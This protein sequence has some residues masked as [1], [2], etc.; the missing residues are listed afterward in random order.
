MQATPDK[1][2]HL[3]TNHVTTEK[4][5]DTSNDLG[6]SPRR[7]Q[8][9]PPIFTKHASAGV[10]LVVSAFTV[11]LAAGSVSHWDN[12]FPPRMRFGISSVILRYSA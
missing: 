12:G 3:E 2:S 8:E 4:R 5:T 11:E 10:Y 9:S 7:I 6:R 1:V